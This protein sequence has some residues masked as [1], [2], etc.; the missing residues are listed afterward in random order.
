MH[1][2][3][4]AQLPSVPQRAVHRGA[5]RGDA[6]LQKVC[7]IRCFPFGTALG[8]AIAAGINYRPDRTCLLSLIVVGV[9]NLL[10]DLTRTRL[11]FPGGE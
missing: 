1:F 5:I 2:L 8:I 4:A 10:F 11:D 6:P 9:V 3:L 7:R